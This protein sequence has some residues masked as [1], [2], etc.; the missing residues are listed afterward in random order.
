MALLYDIHYEGGY[1][2]SVPLPK[3]PAEGVRYAV[4]VNGERTYFAPRD[5]EWVEVTASEALGTKL[6][7]PPGTGLPPEQRTVV[8]SV[9]LT[10]ADWQTYHDA[11]GPEWLRAELHKWRRKQAKATKV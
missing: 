8:G 9:R 7:R 10:P 11:G 6:G 5:G 4:C 3:A 2:A 1:D